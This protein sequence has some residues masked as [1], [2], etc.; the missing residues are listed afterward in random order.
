V[1]IARRQPVS[2]AWT[3]ASALPR[4][5]LAGLVLGTVAVLV[6]LAARGQLARLGAI[7]E[8]AATWRSLAHALPVYL[9]GV[10]LAFLYVRLEWALGR[11]WAAAVPAL[12]FALAHVP[13]ALAAG[14]PAWSVAAFF[15]FNAAFVAALLLVLRRYR[16][17]V[18]LGVAHWLMDLAIEAF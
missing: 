8:R 9:E 6:Y 1:L 10:G 12:L 15:A 11:A 17:V 16:D 2:S 7:A 13:R 14:D 3:G 18:A 5:L 4:R